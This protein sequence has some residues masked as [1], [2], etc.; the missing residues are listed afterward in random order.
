MRSRIIFGNIYKSEEF[1]ALSTEDKLLAIYLMTNEGIGLVPAYKLNRTEI[2][3]WLGLDRKDIDNKIKKLE[4]VGIY[5]IDDYIVICNLYSSYVYH[6]GEDNKNKSAMIKE[7]ALLPSKI[8][9]KLTSL[10]FDIDGTFEVPY[11]YPEGTG[12]VFINKKQETITHKQEIE[13]EE[14]DYP[15]W[16]LGDGQSALGSSE[17]SSLEEE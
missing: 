2:C 10:G 7:Y 17:D 11:G 3:F 6:K 9:E 14:V 1:M 5:R 12:M 16:M 13:E 4:S 8:Q 15:D